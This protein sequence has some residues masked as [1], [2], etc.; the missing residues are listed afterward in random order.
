MANSKK[1]KELIQ[2]LNEKPFL[3]TFSNLDHDD[4]F[5]IKCE[6]TKPYLK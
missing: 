4:V 3:H 5:A 2:R 1:Y 6:V